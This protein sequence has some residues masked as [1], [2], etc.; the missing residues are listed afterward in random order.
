MAAQCSQTAMEEEDEPEIR[1]TPSQPIPAR[2]R[3][4][5]DTDIPVASKL[6]TIYS[7]SPPCRQ[8]N[9]LSPPTSLDPARRR[10]F[11]SSS[12]ES[13]SSTHT[14]N[15]SFIREHLTITPRHGF[16]VAHGGINTLIEEE[17]RSKSQ[18]T[19]DDEAEI[20]EDIGDLNPNALASW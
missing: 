15:P 13:C 19:T 9:L 18:T 14:K 4:R 12:E 3:A 10:T 5:S 6:H 2:V 20:V 7:V 16:S 8:A 1:F 17:E 11:S